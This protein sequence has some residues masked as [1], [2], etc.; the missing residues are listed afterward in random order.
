MPITRR[1]LLA[2]L[3]ATAALPWTPARALEDEPFPVSTSD[4]RKIQYKYR[5][6][7]K[8]ECCVVAYW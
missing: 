8:Y 1:R 7:T 2:A 5:Y 4:E 3:A 6:S